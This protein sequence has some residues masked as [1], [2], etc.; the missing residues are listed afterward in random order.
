MN[1]LIEMKNITKTYTLGDETFKALDDVSLSVNEGE[2]LSIV[3]P[4]GSGKSTL[5]NMIGCLDVPDEGSYHLD[6]VDVYKLNDNKLSEIRNKKIGFIFQQFNLLTKLSALENVELPLI[7]GGYSL[8]KREKI[9][10]NCL[11]KVGLSDKKGNL[12]TQLS[13]G[14]QQRVAIA[15]ALSASPSILLADEPTGA[16]DSKTGKEVMS[17]LKELN[18]AGNTIVMI[19]HDLELARY[20]TR[21]IRIQ[22]G[23]LY[24]EEVAN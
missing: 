9:A 16:L 13:G 4:S 1:P 5:M 8:S 20:G 6:S 3:G 7:Y 24:H 17:I 18:A 2:F 19:T 23:R 10:L 22:D 21:S 14:Q 11:E 15:R 12:P